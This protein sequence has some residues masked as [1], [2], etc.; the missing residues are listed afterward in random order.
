MIRPSKKWFACL[1][2]TSICALAAGSFNSSADNI[3]NDANVSISTAVDR[4]I[5]TNIEEEEKASDTDAVVNAE[6]KDLTRCLGATFTGIPDVEGLQAMEDEAST[7]ETEVATT[8]NCQYP[9]YANK[10]VVIINGTVNIREEANTNCNVVSYAISGQEV[11]VKQKGAEWSLIVANGYEGYIK[12]EFLAFGD[13]AAEYIQND[14]DRIAVINS[15]SLRLRES[16]T[17]DS[18][19]LAYLPAGGSYLVL[20]EGDSWTY[21]QVNS[22]LSGYVNNDY[23]T[24]TNGHANNYAAVIVQKEEETTTSNTTES[25]TSNTTN[26]S[27]HNTTPEST[28][29]T[30]S[31]TTNIPTGGSGITSCTG[32][33]IANYAVQFVG[34]PYVYGGTSLTNGADCSGFVMRVYSDF[35][36]SLSRTAYYQAFEGIQV[37]ISELQAGDLI[38]FDYGTGTIQHVG[39]YIGNNQ[40]VHAANSSTGIVI[41]TL[42]SSSVYTCRRIIY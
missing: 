24:V 8:E 7:E 27:S 31:T 2:V 10:A 22:N 25:T 34:N 32:Q 4:Y 40:Y 41:T 15:D 12:N 3:Y 33:D 36:I 28:D 26:N 13:E 1:A 21:I 23:I 20:S 29:T 35:G 42:N 16:A 6:S 18:E 19:C 39:I 14:Y 5:A 30:D 37:S 17:T 11:T 9:E 38:I